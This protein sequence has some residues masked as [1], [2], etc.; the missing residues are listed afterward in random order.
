MNVAPSPF[1]CVPLN[2]QALQRLSIRDALAARDMT[3]VYRQLQR[4]G[5][6]QQRIAAATG[7]SQPEISAIIHGRR[8]MA[9]DVF[10]RIFIG[11]GVPLCQVGMAACCSCCGHI[12]DENTGRQHSAQDGRT[13]RRTAPNSDAT[14]TDNIGSR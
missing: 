4:I 10:H 8:V 6:S 3:A 1:F 7:Q 9:Y 12:T 5:L 11:L 2:A 13:S 14:S